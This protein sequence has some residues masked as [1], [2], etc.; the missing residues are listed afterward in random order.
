MANLPSFLPDSGSN[1]HKLHFARQ[2]SSGSGSHYQS[3]GITVVSRRDVNGN[4]EVPLNGRWGVARE[5]SGPSG[6]CVKFPRG[7]EERR[8]RSRPLCGSSVSER[9]LEPVVPPPSSCIS[10][11]RKNDSATK[12][13]HFTSRN[14]LNYGGLK[15]KDDQRVPHQFIPQP[16]EDKLLTSQN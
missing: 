11:G 12:K 1:R 2:R 13:V 10:K 3:E 14:C 8:K 7:R 16:E 4:D 5:G 6:H 9:Q 15:F